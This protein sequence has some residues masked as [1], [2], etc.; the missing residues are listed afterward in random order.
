M[1]GAGEVILLVSLGVGALVIATIPV[2][3]LI[4]WAIDG[5]VDPW[6]AGFGVFLY[7]CLIAGVMGAPGPLKIFLLAFLV[8]GAVLT[9]VLGK[10]SDDVQLARMS[11]DKFN[12]LGAI[13]ERDPENAPIRIEFARMLRK[14][15]ELDRAIEHLQ[16]VLQRYPKLNFQV[17]AEL[18][19]W[20]RER[21]RRGVPQPIF[22]HRC[23]AEN[24]WNA[25]HCESCAAAFGTRA[26]MVQKMHYEGGPKRVIRG[27]IV[28]A[29]VVNL[30]VFALIF[31]PRVLPI[32]IVGVLV[33]S[34]VLVGAWLFMRWVGGDMGTVGD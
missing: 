34:T 18:D 12:Q 24:L 29:S 23:S 1:P 25:T 27:W 17:K 5:G 3:K 8:L 26:G 7:V 14:Q 32:E 19:T 6:A 28:T 30:S 9:P 20:L 11:S 2:I 15:G 21:D 33:I 10:A 31:L 16:W 4:G 22:C 13:L